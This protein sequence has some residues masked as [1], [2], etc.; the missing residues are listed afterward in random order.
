MAVTGLY[1]SNFKNIKTN[2][3]FVFNIFIS[4]I[5]I[6]IIF[7]CQLVPE[8]NFYGILA[9]L[10]L[11]CWFWGGRW[12]WIRNRKKNWPL[13]A[14]ICLLIPLLTQKSVTSSTYSSRLSRVT[15][16]NKQQQQCTQCKQQH[17]T[18]YKQERWS[19]SLAPR[20]PPGYPESPPEINNNSNNVHNT[21][22]I[23]AND[24]KVRIGLNGLLGHF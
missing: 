16:W 2:G 21:N 5:Y 10:L 17:S 11:C 24:I 7:H 12:S 3:I 23:D 22:N 6:P 15:S 8:I 9:K 20:I 14:S 19:L 18:R 4:N 13:K 1:I